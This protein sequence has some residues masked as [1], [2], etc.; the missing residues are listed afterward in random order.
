M[1]DE[2]EDENDALYAIAMVARRSR[3]IHQ[4]NRMN[5]RDVRAMMTAPET[6]YYYCRMTTDF[7]AV[8]P[9]E[10]RHIGYIIVNE[11][12]LAQID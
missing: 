7:D 1:E 11:L 8:A 10:Y 3:P 5:S 2:D 9:N 6:P 12:L 4:M